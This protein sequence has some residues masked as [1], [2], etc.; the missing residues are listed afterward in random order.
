[1]GIGSTQF[2]S[3]GLN[4]RTIGIELKE[5]YFKQSLINVGNIEAHSTEEKKKIIIEQPSLFGE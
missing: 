2:V 3:L 1:M 4:R 5:S